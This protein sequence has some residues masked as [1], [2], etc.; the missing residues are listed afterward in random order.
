L[1]ERKEEAKEWQPPQVPPAFAIMRLQHYKDE[2]AMCSIISKCPCQNFW[3]AIVI[4][5]DACRAANRGEPSPQVLERMV[6]QLTTDASRAEAM[7]LLLTPEA[8]K[9]LDDWGDG[10][11][12][13]EEV[14]RSMA[15]LSS[16]DGSSTQLE[17]TQGSGRHQGAPDEASG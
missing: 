17:Q 9:Q 3:E 14:A 12:S 4:F 2:L 6:V 5:H 8:Q 15:L 10:Y 11:Y 13:M 1:S 7:H 16:D